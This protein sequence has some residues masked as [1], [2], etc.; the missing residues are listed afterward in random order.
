MLHN[1]HRSE[2]KKKKLLD[3]AKQMQ[4]CYKL[5]LVNYQ[6]S[7]FCIFFILPIQK[8]LSFSYDYGFGDYLYVTGFYFGNI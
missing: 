8:T 7:S 6:F 5:S 1:K 3:S 4:S 2:E